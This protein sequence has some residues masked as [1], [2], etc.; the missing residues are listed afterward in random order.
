MRVAIVS[1]IHGNQ[2]AFDAVMEDVRSV[3]HDAIWCLGDLVGYGADPD[4]CVELARGEAD[5]CLVGNHDLA[6]RGDLPLTEFSRGAALAAE[7]T[8]RTMQEGNLAYLGELEPA[9]VHQAVGLYHASPRDPVWEYVLSSPLATL[10][11]DAQR[12]RVCM[13][14]HSHVALAFGRDDGG[15][16]HGRDPRRRLRAGHLQR[17]VAAEPGLGGPAARRGPPSGLAAAR[18]RRVGGPLA[19]G[20]VRHRRCGS[21]D[22][23]GQPARG[24]G[25]A[26]AIRAM[27]PSRAF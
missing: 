24:A 5:L 19:A 17:G 2:Q 3:E 14:G 9:D 10:C 8:R 6:V 15:R 21:G 23:G 25:R 11:L 27:S 22:P 12:H 7:W 13:I 18:H 4:A 1:D 20:P 16:D 26:L